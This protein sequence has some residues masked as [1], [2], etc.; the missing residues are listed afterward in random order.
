MQVR[1]YGLK[2]TLLR[3]LDRLRSAGPSHIAPP[4]AVHCHP[5][6]ED[7][8]RNV[9]EH[10]GYLFTLEGLAFKDYVF[11]DLGC[12]AGEVLSWAA[13][14][15]FW[16]VVGIEIDKNL[17]ATALAKAR[18]CIC[19]CMDATDY[20]FPPNPAVIYLYN[21]FQ[22]KTMDRLIRNVERSLRE[23]PRDL[24]IIYVNPWEHRKFARSQYLRTVAENSDVP[25][26][27]FCIFRSITQANA[28]RPASKIGR[29]RLSFR[30]QSEIPR[31]SA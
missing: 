6:R 22:G 18:D 14:R 19:L 16:A 7:I 2:A 26:W 31:Q 30:D 20:E 17:A 5:T 29:R 28:E 27:E 25:E 21:P 10:L 1:Q 23:E 11:I 9:T 12:G 3:Y 8:F 15:S 13:K 24:W 4:D